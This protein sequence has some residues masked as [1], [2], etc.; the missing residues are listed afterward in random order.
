[1]LHYKLPY[2]I[3]LKGDQDKF[4]TTVGHNPVSLGQLTLLASTSKN[5][6]KHRVGAKLEKQE[7]LKIM[8][9]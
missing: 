4:S 5:N 3:T 7:L 8:K 6:L 9:K 1:M 2:T